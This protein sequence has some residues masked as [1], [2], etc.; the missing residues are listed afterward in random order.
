MKR[1]PI[2]LID[3]GVG[4]FTV[5][6]VLENCFPEE[7]FIYFGDSKNMPYGE[8]TNEEIIRLVD[9]DIAFLEE[10]GVKLIILA[11]NTASSL[12][13]SLSSN[14]KL[15]SIIEAGCLAVLDSQ[16]SGPVGLI[17]TRATVNNQA[18]DKVIPRYSDQ[19]EFISY[20]TPK[21]AQVINNN[22]DEINL[23]KKNITISIEPI[24]EKF[25]VKNL[26]LG[27]THYPIVAETIRELYPDIWLIDPAQKMVEIVNE[28]LSEQKIKRD[29]N[30]KG[31]VT[32]YITGGELEKKRS[33]ILLKELKIRYD[34]LYI[35]E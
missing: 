29:D 11:C 14:V 9:Q 6:K 4:G 21:L 23:L 32:I 10:K 25:P 12:I 22:L 16:T 5:L 15:F 34:H 3:S 26:L 33:E 17:A 19:V 27:C 35:I 30:K 20:G 13:E 24:L 28:Y 31:K 2:G 18:Y 1:R 8:K 7:D